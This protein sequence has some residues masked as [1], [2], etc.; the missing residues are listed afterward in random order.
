MII[1]LALSA[2]YLTREKILKPNEIKYKLPFLIRTN[3][4]FFAASLLTISIWYLRV[5]TVQIISLLYV[6]YDL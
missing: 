3:L 4:N 1:I 5:S 2:S 6:Y